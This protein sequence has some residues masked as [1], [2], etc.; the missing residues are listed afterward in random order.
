MEP[1]S[2]SLVELAL[3]VDVRMSFRQLVFRGDQVSVEFVH[4]ECP[5]ELIVCGIWGS[6]AV[7]F[8]SLGRNVSVSYARAYPVSTDLTEI[9]QVTLLI[10]LIEDTPSIFG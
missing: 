3:E 5:L 8:E 10:C 1:D 2:V 9:I 6:F 7:D 4:A